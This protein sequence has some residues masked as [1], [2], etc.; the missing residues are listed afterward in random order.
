V[1]A[2]VVKRSGRLTAGATAVNGGTR[3][4]TVKTTVVNNEETNR[5]NKK[6]TNKQWRILE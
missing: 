1:K 4:P 6:K 2:T 5:R 3:I